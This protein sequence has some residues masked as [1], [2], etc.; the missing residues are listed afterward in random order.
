MAENDKTKNMMRASPNFGM[1]IGRYLWICSLACVSSFIWAIDSPYDDRAKDIIGSL[2]ATP[3]S[4]RGG[5]ARR[6]DDSPSSERPLELGI[7]VYEKYPQYRR[8][9][10]T[11]NLIAFFK[12]FIPSVVIVPEDVDVFLPKNREKLSLYKRLW[13]PGNAVMFSKPMINGMLAYIDAGGLLISNE[14]MPII[15][16]D[17]NYLYNFNRDERFSVKNINP[18]LGIN[19]GNSAYYDK[20]RVLKATPPTFGLETNVW[21]EL[22]QQARGRHI[23]DTPLAHSLVT[24]QGHSERHG[25]FEQPFL[26]YKLGVKGAAIYLA[27]TSAEGPLNK[28]V[29]NILSRKTLKWLTEQ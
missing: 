8:E 17:E 27:A 10:A 20:I 24:A 13:I 2:G 3:S 14:S 4:P 28:L 11:R 16:S 7:V 19:G 22:P 21:I 25:S 23:T 15:D 29:E 12:K 26:C 9:N 5:V 18:V 1:K 6:D